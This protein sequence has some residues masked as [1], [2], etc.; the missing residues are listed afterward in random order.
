MNDVTDNLREVGREDVSV[1]LELMRQ[2]NR[3]YQYDFQED[4]KKSCIES[5]IDRFHLGKMWLIQSEGNSVGYI[6]LTWGFSFEYLGR[7]A[8]IDEL[9]ILKSFRGEG[10]GTLAIRYVQAYCVQH[11]IRAIHLE[12]EPENQRG[13]NTYQRMHFAD[14]GRYLMTYKVPSSRLFLD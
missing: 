12:V 11:G 2:F 13:I 7:D 8:F 14:T 9:F 3:E 4:L 6:V 10:L 1:I 5:F